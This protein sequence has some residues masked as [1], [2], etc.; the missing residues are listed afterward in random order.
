[1]D[2]KT[3]RKRTK[4]KRKDFSELIGIPLGTIRNWEQG[5]RKPPE[6]VVNLIDKYVEM[7]EKEGKL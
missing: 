3:I 5:I 7:L 1:M 6:Y 2:I 4:L